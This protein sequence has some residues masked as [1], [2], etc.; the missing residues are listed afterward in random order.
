MWIAY[1]DES[2]EDERSFMTLAAVVC[3]EDQIQSVTAALDEVVIQ[4]AEHYGTNP[5][6]EIHVMDILGRTSGWESLPSTD[7]SVQVIEGVVDLLCSLPGIQF[8]MRG[9]NVK[10]HRAKRYP[11][12][13][14]PRRVGIQ[15]VLEKCNEYIRKP[16]S[17]LV[18]VDDMAKPEEHRK[19]LK[20][21]RDNGTPGFRK[22][23]LKT[24]V[25]NIYFMPSNY[26]RG[27]QAAD[28]I[29]YVHRRQFT[30]TEATDPRAREVSERIWA[31]LVASG[32]VRTY[33]IW[34]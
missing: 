29:A 28:V 16:G 33:G 5:D 26:A 23:K 15:H 6:S 18:I 12:T 22:S 8:F 20:L 3:P 31:K 32:K 34:P 25:D 11:E 9:V 7:A 4:A 30:I 13:W 1:L 19:L 14:N 17:L 27:L 10:A 2:A 24:I 21:Y